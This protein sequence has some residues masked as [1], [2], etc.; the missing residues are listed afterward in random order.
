MQTNLRFD[1]QLLAVEGEHD[2]HCMLELQALCQRHPRLYSLP[3][4]LFELHRAIAAQQGGDLTAQD[5]ALLRC[6]KLTSG[7]GSRE[8]LWHCQRFAALALINAG[9]LA[10]GAA[11]LEA[12]HRRAEHEVLGGARLLCAYDQTIVLERAP[13]SVRDALAPEATDAPSVWS[14]KVRVLAAL[15][16]LH[17]AYAA[18][19]LVRAD[20]LVRFPCDRDYLG[21]L[22]ALAH[23]SIALGARDYA[24]ILYEL[25]EP[26]AGMFAAHIA[27]YCEGSVATLRGMLAR[28]AGDEAR[29]ETQLMA[30]IASCERAGLKTSAQR[31]R[32]ELSLLRRS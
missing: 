2:V 7:V 13:A 19:S 20:Q 17:T 30:G 23:A 28:S 6:E 8:L 26:Y 14:T 11:A 16:D 15:G 29:A 5:A 27:F 10:R 32:R 24:T 3:P 25:L 1:H 4:A 31:A 12:L 9:Q 22:G 21:T 18:L